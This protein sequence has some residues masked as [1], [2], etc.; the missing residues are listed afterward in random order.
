[1]KFTGLLKLNAYYQYVY[2]RISTVVTV[3]PGVTHSSSAWQGAGER[4]RSAVCSCIQECAYIFEYLSSTKLSARICIRAC[5]CCVQLYFTSFLLHCRLSLDLHTCT[6][7]VR[8][9]IC[10]QGM[11]C[12]IP[13]LLYSCTVHILQG[14]GDMY[15]FTSFHNLH[16]IPPTHPYHHPT[17]PMHTI[18]P[19]FSTYSCIRINR[20]S[21]SCSPQVS[22]TYSNT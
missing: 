13:V 10:I 3:V 2:S 9:C 20:T 17:H 14:T 18:L 12:T 19:R 11:K 1:M 8:I 4:V 6:Y 22:M 15:V 7:Y 5:A 16:P 21:F